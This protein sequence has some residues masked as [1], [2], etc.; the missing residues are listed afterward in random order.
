MTSLRHDLRDAWRALRRS[1]SYT[2]VVASMLALGIGVNTAIF[3]VVDALVLKSLPYADADRLVRAA[4]WPRTGGN[5]TVAPA[6]FV[7][8]QPAAS[9][10]MQLEA[11]RRQRV[12]LLDSGDPQTIAAATV[13]FGYLDLLGVR[14]AL[15]RTFTAEDAAPDA[16]CRAVISH[17]LWTTRM[18]ADPAA[19]GRT[20][21]L[22]DDACTLVGVLPAHSVFGRLTAEVYVPM[23]LTPLVSPQDR[24][25]I[26]R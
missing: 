4:E 9:G 20:F 11:Y 19:V 1:P 15:G 13:T 17:A 6:A 14:A 21:R 24:L 2:L 23:V 5:F 12:V 16:G 22:T 26:D 10:F 25:R 7:H 8:W 18:N 3:S